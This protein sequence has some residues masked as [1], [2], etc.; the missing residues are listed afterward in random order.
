M[1]R[2]L[3]LTFLVFDLY[4]FQITKKTIIYIFI[5]L[6]LYSSF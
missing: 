5:L 1:G 3:L 6:F 4:S 2:T